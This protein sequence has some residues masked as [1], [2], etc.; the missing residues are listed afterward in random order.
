MSTIRRS[1]V[2]ELPSTIVVWVDSN[3]SRTILATCSAGTKGT[4]LDI[5]AANQCYA[6]SEFFR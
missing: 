3:P 5:T 6:N 1:F 4:E 2:K